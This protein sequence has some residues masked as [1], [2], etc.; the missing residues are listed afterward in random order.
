MPC[1]LNAEEEEPNTEVPQGA[2][3][4]VAPAKSQRGTRRLANADMTSLKRKLEELIGSRQADMNKLKSKW[5]RMEEQYWS[6]VQAIR[7]GI[8]FPP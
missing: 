1:L 5:M 3:T 2:R 6:V 8:S 7:E 4:H